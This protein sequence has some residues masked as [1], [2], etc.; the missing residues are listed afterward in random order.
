MRST[1]AD[2][3]NDWVQSAQK[4]VQRLSFQLW[5]HG[6]SKGS[7]RSS[8]G[9]DTERFVGGNHAECRVLDRGIAVECLLYFRKTSSAWVVG[10]SVVGSSGRLGDRRT[11][12]NSY[13]L[14][15]EYVHLTRSIHCHMP[16]SLL[17][18]NVATRGSR[19]LLMMA[20]SRSMA[21]TEF[22]WGEGKDKAVVVRE[23]PSLALERRKSVANLRP[24]EVGAW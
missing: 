16:S 8:S 19:L 11:L 20:E 6:S 2:N 7:C 18:V 4:G 17:K 15:L 5:S 24:P 10:K 9:T 22:L 14:P 3:T 1:V 12:L 13:S 21:A 23:L